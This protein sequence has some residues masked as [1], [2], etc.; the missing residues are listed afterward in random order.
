[1][2]QTI[3]T[4]YSGGLLPG[5][6]TESPLN[7]IDSYVAEGGI[8]FGVGVQQG[9]A[10]HQVELAA[11]GGTLLGVALRCHKYP[12]D[13]A[14]DILDG[15]GVSVLTKGVVTGELAANATKN[16]AA[17]VVTA[18]GADQGKFTP[19]STNNLL[20]GKF[21]EAGSDGDIVTVEVEL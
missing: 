11:S 15:Q 20:V 19:T 1:M 3:Y 13:Q 9:T 12:N 2:A 5:V 6:V 4:Q 14:T 8:A 10:G 16:A 21:L 18:A 17:Y 7:K